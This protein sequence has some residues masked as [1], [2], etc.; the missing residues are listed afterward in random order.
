VVLVPRPYE[1]FKPL[2]S[3][4]ETQTVS[5]KTRGRTRLSHKRSQGGRVNLRDLL[6]CVSHH[7]PGVRA[8]AVTDTGHLVDRYLD[9]YKRGPYT[10]RSSESSQCLNSSTDFYRP[11]AG[12]SSA[13][14]VF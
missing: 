6:F 9:V 13:Y 4:L 1:A 10:P 11:A 7:C 5:V 2:S 8:Y 3:G 14:S 12:C